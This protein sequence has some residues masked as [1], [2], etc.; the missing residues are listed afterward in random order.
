MLYLGDIRTLA[1]DVH[2]CSTADMDIKERLLYSPEE[3]AELLGIG[4]T[5]LYALIK[6]GELHTVK[7]GR[8][9]LL[10]R[11]ELQDYVVGL[12]DAI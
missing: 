8:R 11:D 3:A 7:I 10:L 9:T 2:T 6:A 12:I 4:R 5:T 1:A